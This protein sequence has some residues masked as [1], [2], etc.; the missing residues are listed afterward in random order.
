M[1][2]GKGSFK[3]AAAGMHLPVHFSHSPGGMATHWNGVKGMMSEKCGRRINVA[4]EEF[5]PFAGTIN[6]SKRRRRAQDGFKLGSRQA[7]ATPAPGDVNL[8]VICLPGLQQRSLF[9]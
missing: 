1:G 4:P 2:S 8:E 3:G 9:R 6:V 7:Q 5:V